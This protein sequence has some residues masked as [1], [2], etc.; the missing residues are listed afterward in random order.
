MVKKYIFHKT[1]IKHELKIIQHKP[2]FSSFPSSIGN[3][4]KIVKKG[5][6]DEYIIGNIF[7]FKIGTFLKL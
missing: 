5:K 6:R 2:M 1:G 7:F 4:K 3:E